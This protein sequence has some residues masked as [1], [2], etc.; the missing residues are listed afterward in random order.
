MRNHTGVRIVLIGKT[1]SGKSCTGNT[2]LRR[3]AF[4]SSDSANSVTSECKS[5]KS[6]INGRIVT[7]VDTPGIFDTRHT[8]DEIQTEI[9]RCICMVVPGPHAIILVVPFGRFTEET[10]ESFDYFCKQFG[11]DMFNY[12]I[13][14]FTKSEDLKHTE[15]TLDDYVHNS[16]RLACFA[17]KCGDRYVGFSNT[18][19]ERNKG[20][21][22]LN[23][24]SQIDAMVH[25]NGGACYTNAIFE[26][27]QER[28][29]MD[30][31]KEKEERDK[32]YERQVRLIE[33]DV[34]VKYQIKIKQHEKRISPL[35]REDLT[36]IHNIEKMKNELEDRIEHEISELESQK[37]I[38][39]EEL[40]TQRIQ[41]SE[42]G[43]QFKSI[44]KRC[45]SYV[46]TA[47]AFFKKKEG[48]SLK[49]WIEEYNGSHV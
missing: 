31:K 22:V 10:Q 17:K 7:V 12:L 40:T 38:E 48:S 42:K 44:K 23:L 37:N 36:T 29:T 3:Q 39:I 43:L 15:Q 6:K 26:R 14:L 1:G 11:D 5:E 25:K 33:R 16:S 18:A 49:H 32:E 45:M 2:I 27:V 34:S 4:I 24:L 28:I 21:Q 19:S 13:I 47:K 20:K 41:A 8:D 46:E 9:F 30:I 35:E